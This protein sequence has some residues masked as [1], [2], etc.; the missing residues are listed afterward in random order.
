MSFVRD[1]GSFT[2]GAKWL[3]W[4]GTRPDG[5]TIIPP[6]HSQS[7]WPSSNS[8]EE[9]A[10]IESDEVIRF[11]ILYAAFVHDAVR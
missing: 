3:T 10:L 4:A 9:M 11:N 2:G 5:I 6:R 8:G 7:E 1:A